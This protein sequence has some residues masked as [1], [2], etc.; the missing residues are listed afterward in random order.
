SV[1]DLALEVWSRRQWLAVVVFALVFVCTVSIATFLPDIYRSTATVLVEGRQVPE[2]FVRTSVTDELKTRLH[3]ISQEVLSRSRLAELIT[4]FD[5]YADLRKRMPS[6]ALIEQMRND[7]RL[8]LK[9]VEQTGGRGETIAFSLSY[10][11]GDPE[12]VAQVT[13]MLAS[14]YVQE[15]LKIRERQAVGTT[16]FLKVQ[17]ETMKKRLGEH[18]RRLSE[19]KKH[20]SAELPQQ[21]VVNLSTLERLN[22]QLRLNGDKQIRA[23]E[24]RAAMMKQ[25]A[26]SNS[27][28]RVSSP[29]GATARTARL[30]QELMELRRRFS[31]KYPDVIRVRAEIADLERQLSEA[32]AN[33]RPAME[34]VAPADPSPLH[35]KEALRGADAEIKTLKADEQSLYRDI[36]AYQQRVEKAPERE[37]EFQ[38]L[39]QDYEATKELYYSLLKRYEDAK[40]AGSM[41]QQKGEQ[42]RILDPATA[43]EHL[44][45][46]NRVRLIFMGLMLSLGLA[47]GVVMLVEKLDTSFHTVDDLRV[48][49]GVP[50]LVS[51]PRIVTKADARWRQWQCGLAAISAMLGLVLIV[52]SSYLV[53]HGNEQLVG[54]FL[55]K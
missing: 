9:E 39:S 16:E 13:N 31:D 53:A 49:S 36:A 40:V 47:A 11:G 33:R 20:Y 19:F 41:E 3:T 32:K 5:L 46:P 50:V 21:V 51:I 35:L 7:I 17:L 18:E 37:Q 30:K 10:R 55:R 34:P 15:N 42:F 4:R 24:R 23:M 27:S 44:A 2:T 38:A 6:K 48:F 26:E 8:E 43:A 28:G 52:G 45:A 1:F 22:A 12:K 54:L 29:D 25:Q 14:F